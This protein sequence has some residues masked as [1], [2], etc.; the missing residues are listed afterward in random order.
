MYPCFKS[1]LWRSSHEHY[2]FW[3]YYFLWLGNFNNRK[4]MIFNVCDRFS[5]TYN[6]LNI[7]SACPHVSLMNI[8]DGFIVDLIKKNCGSGMAILLFTC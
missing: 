7:I 3:D 2:V 6:N 4:H 5:K 8:Y 1:K